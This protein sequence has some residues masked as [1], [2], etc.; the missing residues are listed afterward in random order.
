WQGFL[1]LA[2]YSSDPPGTCTIQVRHRRR[3]SGPEAT[4]LSGSC[5]ARIPEIAW[6]AL[7]YRDPGYVFG[8]DSRDTRGQDHVFALF[9]HAPGYFVPGRI[10]AGRDQSGAGAPPRRHSGHFL[11]EFVLWRPNEGYAAEADVGRRQTYRDSTA[12]VCA[13]KR[14]YRLRETEAVSDHP[15]QSLRFARKPQATRDEPHD[16]RMGQENA[17]AIVERVWGT[18]PSGAFAPDGQ[19]AV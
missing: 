17:L 1:Q 8:R 6:C 11:P 3:Q 14:P 18:E 13:R 7:T 15:L 4:G 2:G 5:L 16:R 12:G 19:P 9:S 10:G